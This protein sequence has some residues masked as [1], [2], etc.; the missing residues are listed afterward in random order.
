MVGKKWLVSENFGRNKNKRKYR[1]GLGSRR[2]K[3]KGTGIVENLG[4]LL[5]C[6]SCWPSAV[7]E[8]LKFRLFFCNK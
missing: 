1:K 7:E 3:V 2:E 8:V 6:W 4:G 5:E